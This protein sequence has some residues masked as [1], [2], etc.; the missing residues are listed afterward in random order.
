MYIMVY[1][2]LQ[3]NFQQDTD[4]KHSFNL[5]KG[6][7]MKNRIKILEWLAEY[8]YKITF[9]NLKIVNTKINREIFWNKDEEI[10]YDVINNFINLLWPILYI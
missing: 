4:S 10:S 8:L 1:V 6:Q 5:C 9:E 3:S 2:P 7:S